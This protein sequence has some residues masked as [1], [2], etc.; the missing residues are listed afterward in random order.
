MLLDE[1][2]IC[3]ENLF[4]DTSY[5]KTIWN[6]FDES[7]LEMML[8]LSD[9]SEGFDVFYKLQALTIGNN[10]CE[11]FLKTLYALGY[12]KAV[13]IDYNDDTR[14]KPE[15][16]AG[17]IT[18]YVNKKND[19]DMIVMGRQTS[20]GSNEKTPLLTA[21]YLHWSCITQV[22]NIE[23]VD[24]KSIKVT[25]QCDEGILTQI[26]STPCVLS[27]GNVANSYLRVPTL[28]DRMKL[29]KKPIEVI[30]PYEI[31]MTECEDF[32]SLVELCAM[33]NLNKNRECVMIEGNSPKEKAEYLYE[34]YLKERLKRL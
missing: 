14:F 9:L 13:R 10:K 32:G 5:V 24:E 3:D 8:K 4:I 15:F 26:V 2:W 16:I 25:S 18:K 23:P 33:E 30:T 29:G 17:L 11:S 28:K 20:D 21:E 12:D 7:A 6:C 1:D 22:I 31:G 34:N 19:V 27:I